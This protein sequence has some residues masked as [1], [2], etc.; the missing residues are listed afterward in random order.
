[1]S[2][3]SIVNSDYANRFSYSTDVEITQELLRCGVD[4]EDTQFERRTFTSTNV[5]TDGY[6]GTCEITVVHQSNHTLLQVTIF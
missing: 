1:M 2:E 4:L 6:A 5:L 3:I